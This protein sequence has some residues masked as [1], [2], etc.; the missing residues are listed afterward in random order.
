MMDLT[1]RHC[2]AFLRLLSTRIR[3][4]TEMMVTGS[5]VHGDRERFL[6]YDQSEHP[7]ALQLGGSDPAQL[8]RCA[9][10]AEQSGYDEVN[11]N[12]GCPS[13]RVKS[14]QFGVCLM[15]QPQRVANCVAAMRDAVSILRYTCEYRGKR[16]ADVNLKVT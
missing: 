11:L 1:D 4:Y 3:L 7:L 10:Y 13:D 15:K 2:R 16:V 6:A 12:V 9:R 14:A 5:L 8:A